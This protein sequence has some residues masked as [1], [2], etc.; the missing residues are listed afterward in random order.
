MTET[1]IVPTEVAARYSQAAR[2]FDGLIE[3]SPTPLTNRVWRFHEGVRRAI[4]SPGGRSPPRSL[5]PRL[6]LSARPVLGGS[7][8]Q[9][10][11]TQ[12]GSGVANQSRA[13]HGVRDVLR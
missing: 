11:H 5:H 7:F 1:S 2:F 12:R 13:H 6:L 3:L 10:H 8:C 9:D 4:L